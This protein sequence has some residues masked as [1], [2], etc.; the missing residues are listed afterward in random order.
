MTCEIDPLAPIPGLTDYVLSHLEPLRIA[1]GTTYLA[2]RIEALPQEL[3][4]SI[5]QYDTLPMADNCTLEPTRYK[6]PESWMLGLASG[7][8]LPWLEHLDQGKCAAKHREKPDGG[9]EWDW[10]LLVRR[11]A[12]TNIFERGQPMHSAPQGLRNLRRVWRC[13]VEMEPAKV[14][15]EKILIEE[16]REQFSKPRKTAQDTLP[17]R[18]TVAQQAQQPAAHVHAPAASSSKSQK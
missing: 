1:P 16:Y 3:Q 2:D 9:R 6:D 13:C 17:S 11:L 7:K 18:S 15:H 12:Q 8:A 5:S 14:D 10:E 4:D